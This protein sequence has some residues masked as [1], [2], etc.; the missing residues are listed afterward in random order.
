MESNSPFIIANEANTRIAKRVETRWLP[1]GGSRSILDRRRSLIGPMIGRHLQGFTKDTGCRHFAINFYFLSLIFIYSFIYSTLFIDFNNN[2]TETQIH[3]HFNTFS[4]IIVCTVWLLLYYL[5]NWLIAIFNVAVFATMIW[6]LLEWFSKYF[7]SFPFFFL[8]IEV[9]TSEADYLIAARS[10]E[11]LRDTWIKSRHVEMERSDPNEA[12]VDS[13]IF[14]W[15]SQ[16]FRMNDRD[17]SAKLWLLPAIIKS[18]LKYRV[19]IIWIIFR[20]R[21]DFF[22]ISRPNH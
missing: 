12:I 16:R 2:F 17:S 20:W 1:P 6:Y 7:K 22:L 13:T 14:Q 11:T 19:Q 15:N 9:E 4:L 3:R 10:I 8:L 18:R 5:N 21:W